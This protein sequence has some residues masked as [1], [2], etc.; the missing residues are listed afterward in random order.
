VIGAVARQ[1]LRDAACSDLALLDDDG[2]EARLALNW[3]STEVGRDAVR[4]VRAGQDMEPLLQQLAAARGGAALHGDARTELR[5]M[6]ARLHDGA[7][8]AN[9]VNKTAVLLGGEVPPDA[10]LPFGDLY[11]SEIAE[12]AGGFTLPAAVATVADAF[13]SVSELDALLR[14]RFER[15][16]ASALDRVDPEVRD[17]LVHALERGRFSRLS[18]RTVPKLGPRTI[19]V[20]LA[21]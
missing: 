16:D 2:P 17:M 7:L 8:V 5:R 15:R 6:L 9:P 4:P 13:G 12:L 10:F 11:A 20:D 14:R 18:A 19:G 1:A 3:L 21:E